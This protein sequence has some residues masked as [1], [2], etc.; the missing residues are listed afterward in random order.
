MVTKISVLNNLSFQFCLVLKQPNL[1]LYSLSP[2]ECEMLNILNFVI[3]HTVQ[4][5]KKLVNDI[6]NIHH[7]TYLKYHHLLTFLHIN[8]PFVLISIISRLPR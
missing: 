6:S 2:I 3:I 4:N 5:F 8:H 1:G 7:K